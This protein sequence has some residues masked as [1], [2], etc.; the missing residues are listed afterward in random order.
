MT[1]RN[2]CYAWRAENFCVGDDRRAMD[3]F[4]MDFGFAKAMN[5]EAR[6]LVS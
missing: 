1:L 3:V 5:S 6:P 4:I 2:C